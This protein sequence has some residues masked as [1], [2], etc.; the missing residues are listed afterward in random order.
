MLEGLPLPGG[1]TLRIIKAVFGFASTVCIGIQTM[2]G[3]NALSEK[4]LAAGDSFEEI[5]TSFDLSIWFP[6]MTSGGASLN[7]EL[8]EWLEETSKE[9]SDLLKK[10][11][12]VPVDSSE[13][14]VELW[15]EAAA[16]P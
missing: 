16:E 11:P 2:L 15:A 3:Y 9:I 1:E 14:R 13:S 4:H 12:P 5:L 6:M 7:K 10:T 8:N